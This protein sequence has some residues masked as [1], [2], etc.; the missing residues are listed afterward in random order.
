MVMP[1]CHLLSPGGVGWGTPLYKKYRYVRP[2]RVG[3]LSRFSLKTRIHFAILV[4]IKYQQVHSNKPINHLVQDL[5][6]VDLVG[7]S[8]QL[9]L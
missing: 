6:I 4:Y 2:H 8:V 1:L 5:L 9:N 3:S 7:A